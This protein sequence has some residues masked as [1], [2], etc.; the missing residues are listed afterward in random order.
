MHAAPGQDVAHRAEGAVGEFGQLPQGPAGLVMLHDERLDPRLYGR[1]R[2]WAGGAAE[3]RQ[4]PQV[5]SR[6]IGQRRTVEAGLDGRRP[7]RR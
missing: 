4:G 6:G 1:V 3:R 2:P 5:R 7:P